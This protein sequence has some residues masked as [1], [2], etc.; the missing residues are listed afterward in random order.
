MRVKTGYMS[1]RHKELRLFC[2]LL[3]W[4]TIPYVSAGCTGFQS[5]HLDQFIIGEVMQKSE[6]SE[7]LRALCLSGGRLSG[8]ENAFAAER[9]IVDKARQCGLRNVHLE[10]FPMT[11]W[12]GIETRVVRLTPDES[13]CAGALALCNTKST[14]PSGVTAGV[15][16]AGDG[17][18][19]DF[20]LLGDELHARFALVRDGGDR[21]SEKTAR[22]LEHD[23]AG[24]VVV[25][26]ENHAP[27][28]GTGHR[29]PRPEP[30]IVISHDDGQ[31]IAELLAAGQTVRLNVQIRSEIWEAEPD[32]VVAEIPGHGPHADE[33][34]LLGAH[35]DSWD[36]AEGAIDNGNGSAVILE[37]ARALRAVGWR[38]SRTVRFVWFMGEEQD[39]R[40]S[41]AYVTAH[42]D[43][44]D[45]VVAMI[46]V[47]MPGS[48]RKL[49]TSGPPQFAERL[50]EFRRGM[51]GYALNE[52]IGKLSGGWS[53]YAP[54]VEAGVCGIAL[55]GELGSGVQNYHTVND[56]FECVDQRA[57][58]ESAAVL[59]VLVRQLADD[60]TLKPGICPPDER[61]ASVPTPSSAAQS[62][63]LAGR[64]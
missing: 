57:T 52:E 47:D 28:I 51:A 1:G 34:V 20:D 54:F 30:A 22:A 17:K 44:L 45:K 38:P 26:A 5:A 10:P 25:S 48:P 61:P 21:R 60:P 7:N 32:N 24:L 59:A 31:A 42:R 46:N 8:T 33:I 19:E 43:E 12:R 23:A 29:R 6:L 2:R 53:D 18:P 49:F 37:C 39:L 9:F 41:R 16:D 58:L 62:S 64:H 13:P 4:F 27:I 40:G 11:C 63:R 55:W 56:K 35:L 14:P 36:L 3:L 15:I 50:Q